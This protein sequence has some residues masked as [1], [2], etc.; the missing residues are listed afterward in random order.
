MKRWLIFFAAVWTA[1]AC[2]IA[3]VGPDT[4]PVVTEYDRVVILYAPGYNTISEYLK[5][6]V[7]EILESPPAYIPIKGGKK[8]L[9]VLSHNTARSYD[10]STPTSPYLF[11]IMRDYDGSIICDTLATLEEGL[12]IVDPDIARQVLSI[13]G[14]NF[15]SKHYGMIFSSH[16]TGWLPKGYY[17]TDK[18]E[19]PIIWSGA[20]VPFSQTYRE[21]IPEGAVPYT[22]PDPD[23]IPVKSIG[24]EVEQDARGRT[25]AYEMDLPEFARACPLHLDYLLM[26]CCLMGGIETA[27]ELRNMAD[28]IGF[29]AAEIPADG[30][31]YPMMA[32]H[33]LH[34]TPATPIG[35]C[36]DFYLNA[37]KRSGSQRTAVISYIDCSRLEALAEVSARIFEKYRTEIENV[38]PTAV[39]GFF[40]HNQ[41]FFYDML[42][43]VEKAGVTGEDLAEFTSALNACVLYRNHTEKVMN[44]VKVNRFCGFSMFLPC[45][46][47]NELREF[48]K[49]LAWNKA[50]AL[51]K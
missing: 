37:L 8:A 33:L 14:E 28:Y 36:S 9:L 13:I 27:Y 1:V 24:N 44:S 26:D 32:K 49:G 51:V 11:R 21:D 48:Y 20:P 34:D 23:D 40:R 45:H 50:T 19:N 25:W 3:S 31:Y 38:D 10:F 12:R 4:P 41:H 46:G 29:S 43:I 30:F 35:V 39:Q 22:L 16:G 47:N 42:D 17:G 15:P 18:D 7:R 2:D 6:D 5:G